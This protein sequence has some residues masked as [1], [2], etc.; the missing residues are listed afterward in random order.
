MTLCLEDPNITQE[1]EEEETRRDGSV[2][3]DKGDD[4][5]RT[6]RVGCCIVN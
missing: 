3:E 5:S 4:C 2:S 6:R 1:V